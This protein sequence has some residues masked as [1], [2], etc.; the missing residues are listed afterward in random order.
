MFKGENF[1][2]NSDKKGFNFLSNAIEHGNSEVDFA[3]LMLSL[4]NK[5]ITQ[6]EYNDLSARLGKR[7]EL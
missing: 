2:P 6:E 4:T 5:E 7:L 3:R 1:I